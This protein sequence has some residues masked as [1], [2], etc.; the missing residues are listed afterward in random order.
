VKSVVLL[1]LAGGLMAVKPATAA[2]H[3]FTVDTTLDGVDAQP[4]DGVCATAAGKCTLRAAIME[5]NH[6][7]A[8]SVDVVVPS[9]ANPYVLTILPSGTD[10]ETSGSLHVNRDVRILGGGA[11]RT[12]IDGNGT[13]RV[14]IVT[15]GPNGY[16]GYTDHGLLFVSDLTIRDG[17]T[18]GQGG[19]IFDNEDVD[20]VVLRCVVTGNT[21]AS[22]GGIAG[23]DPS[24]TIDHSTVSGN[25][26]NA[27]PGGGVRAYFVTIGA[28]TISDN[29]ASTVGGG[30]YLTSSGTIF[31]STIAGNTAGTNGSNLGGGGG[32]YHPSSGTATITGTVIWGNNDTIPTH[33]LPTLE[34][35]D[36]TGTFAGST[37]IVRTKSTCT[38]TA[39][40]TDPLLGPLQLNGGEIPTQALLPGSPAIDAGSPFSC[41]FNTPTDERGAH[42]PAGSACDLGAYEYAAGGDVNGDGVRDVSDIFY[43]INYLFAGGPTPMGLGD[44]NGDTKTDVADVF[45]LINFLFAGGPA[46]L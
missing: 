7:S 29:T 17:S 41:T 33:P 10:D 5:S 8:G 3:T 13:D 12:I 44:V 9:N 21:A 43:A 26:A 34:W 6:T 2:D 18:S 23:G 24:L 36:C 19:G 25:V 22:G 20:V 35:S 30:L 32:I 4:G 31:Q 37:N 14:L 46:P 16:S 1:I 39:S 40:E 38:I 15:S 45:Y 28:S 42:R 27:G 11:A